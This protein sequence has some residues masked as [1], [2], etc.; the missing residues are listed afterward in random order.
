MDINYNK[1]LAGELGPV[2]RIQ[3]E[4]GGRNLEERVTFSFLE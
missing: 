1:K 3:S 4:L 2:L